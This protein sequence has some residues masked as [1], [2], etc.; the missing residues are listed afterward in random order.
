MRIDKLR[1]I[2]SLQI[3]TDT[4]ADSADPDDTAQDLHCLPFYYWFKTETVFATLDVSEFR[5]VRVHI[6]NSGVKK[7]IG[8][9]KNLIGL[10]PRIIWSIRAIVPVNSAYFM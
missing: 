10:T 2:M 1:V 6:R 8:H 9:L 7:L 5:D 4:F 3:N